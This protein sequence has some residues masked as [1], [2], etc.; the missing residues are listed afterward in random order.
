MGLMDKVKQ[1]A[2]QALSKAQQGVSQGKVKID[3]AQA[4]H[5]WDGLLGKLG[6]AV[7]AEQRQGGSSDAVAAAMAALDQHLAAH[8]PVQAGAGAPGTADE[9]GTSVDGSGTGEAAGPTAPT[10]AG[11]GP[12]EE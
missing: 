2:E 7:W 8:G 1:S 4:K 11:S 12:T 3:Q 5:Q 9:E 6:A 10:T